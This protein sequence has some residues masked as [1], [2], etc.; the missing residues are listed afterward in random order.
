MTCEKHSYDPTEHDGPI[1]CEKF[2][3][4]RYWCWAC[5]ASVI[6]FLWKPDEVAT[7]KAKL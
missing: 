5:E 7:L 4:Q 6:P 1:I 3:D 2:P